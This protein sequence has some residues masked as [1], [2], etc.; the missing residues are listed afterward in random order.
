[1][2]LDEP[3]TLLDAAEQLLAKTRITL[4]R[5]QPVIGTP[6]DCVID[7]DDTAQ[8]ERAAASAQ[9]DMVTQMLRQVNSHLASTLAELDRVKG[10]LR[11]LVEITELAAVFVDSHLNIKRFTPPLTAIYDVS[12]SD[13]GMPLSQIRA[14][15]RYS[16]LSA[17]FDRICQGEKI[18]EKHLA[19]ADGRSHYLMRMRAYHIVDGSTDGVAIIFASIPGKTT[20]PIAVDRTH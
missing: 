13:I 4:T 1:M 19:S 7:H 10:D 12:L 16:E 14:N 3:E 6:D 17:D 11:N 20:K 8:E 15:L 9:I 2:E 5:D 18:I